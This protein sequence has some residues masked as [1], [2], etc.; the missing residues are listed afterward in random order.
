MPGAA[1]KQP[2]QGVQPQT[3]SWADVSHTVMGS[4]HSLARST[5]VLAGFLIGVL[6]ICEQR[7]IPVL[8]VGLLGQ[9]LWA[10]GWEEAF[11]GLI[12]II[13]CSIVCLIFLGKL[14]EP[15]VCPLVL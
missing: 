10:P 13:I 2:N 7:H 12:I 11:S 8:L 3:R 4:M 1:W 14:V 5:H 15:L 6:L 9:G